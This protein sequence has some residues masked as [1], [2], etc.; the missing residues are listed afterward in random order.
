VFVTKDR[1]GHLRRK[2]QPS[3]LPGKTFM[4]SLIVDDTRTWADWSQGLKLAFVEPQ[5][6]DEDEDRPAA[7]AD[8]VGDER[9]LA[10]VEEIAKAGLDASLRM[11]RA[12]A[13][14]AKDYT[15]QAL[16]RLVLDGRLTERTGA[17]K[18]RLFAIPTSPT[19]AESLTQ[20]GAS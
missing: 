10:A 18:A 16:A 20:D 13:G 2:G 6:R 1:P 8:Q 9:V 4:G 11:V 3:K 17:R 14:M 19:V 12:K 15:D 7:D 5:P